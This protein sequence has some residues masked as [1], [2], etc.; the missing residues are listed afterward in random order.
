[1]TRHADERRHEASKP[2]GARTN[3]PTDPSRDANT[4]GPHFEGGSPP[5]K[6]LAPHTIAW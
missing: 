4:R 3:H 2:A 6:S 5:A 1:M